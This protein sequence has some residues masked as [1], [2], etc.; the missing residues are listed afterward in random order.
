[1]AQ[2]WN[3]A[4][5][6]TGESASMDSPNGEFWVGLMTR[7]DGSHYWSDGTKFD[8]DGGAHLLIF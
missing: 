8:Y 5:Q 7:P 1:M 4:A 3:A 2:L 6:W